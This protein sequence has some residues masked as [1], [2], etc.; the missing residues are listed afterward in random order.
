MNSEGKSTLASGTP[1]SYAGASHS[2]V[3]QDLPLILDSGSVRASSQP[4]DSTA[5]NFFGL[6]SKARKDI[7]ERVL[8]VAH[9]LYVFRDTGPRVETFAPDK[10]PQWRTLLFVNRKM[11][12]EASAVLYGTNSFT[13]LDTTRREIGLLQAFLDC[14]GPVNANLLSHLCINFPDIEGQPG[15]PRCLREGSL[16]DLKLLQ[17][18]CTNMTT[19]ETHVYSNNSAVFTRTDQDD[20][21]FIREALLQFDVQLRAIPS[22][23]KIIIRVYGGTP[24]PSVMA[25][26]QGFGWVVLRGNRNKW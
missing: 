16:Q 24:T 7:Y 3:P 25:F 11:N 22:L 1:L 15:Q 4:T 20:L 19:L 18:K 13:L 21:Q 26:M 17:E 6:P 9:P 8:T 12:S 10:P 23:K 14:I 5:I 2:P